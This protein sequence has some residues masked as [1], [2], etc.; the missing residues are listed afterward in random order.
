MQFFLLH[1]QRWAIA[2]KMQEMPEEKS[3]EEQLYVPCLILGAAAI[4][5]LWV[6]FR[7]ILPDFVQTGCIWYERF[8]IYCPGCG[9]T[10]AVKALLRGD[11]LMSLWYHPLV[12]Y[13]A[14]IYGSFMISQTFA[15]LTG[16]RYTRG[17]RFHSWYLYLAIVI[18]V[19][20][21]IGKNLLRLVWNINL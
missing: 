21:W 18:M 2:S 20:N 17:V 8:H 13:G 10:R 6:Y 14:V 1:W 11:I 5:S 15:R 16:Y 4:L 19:L 12:P 3:L 7:Y 9:G